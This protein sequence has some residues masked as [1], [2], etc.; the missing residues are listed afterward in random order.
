[1]KTARNEKVPY[2]H[3]LGTSSSNAQLT[4]SKEGNDFSKTYTET[5]YQ[6]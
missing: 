5:K 4:N 2:P 6:Y 1:M 3:G